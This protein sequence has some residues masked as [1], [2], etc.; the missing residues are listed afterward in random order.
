MTD[1]DSPAPGSWLADTVAAINA[2]LDEAALTELLT[3]GRID[4]GVYQ[5]R[6]QEL[7]A[8]AITAHLKGEKQAPRAFANY[9][10]AKRSSFH[11]PPF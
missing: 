11:E 6:R 7:I 1:P 10:S 2:S 4:P 5:F 3:T 8:Y 9:I